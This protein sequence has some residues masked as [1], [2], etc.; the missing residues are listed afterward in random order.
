MWFWGGFAW[1]SGEGEVRGGERCLAGPDLRWKG[2]PDLAVE[3]F[4][5]AGEAEGVGEGGI[6]ERF[7]EGLAEMGEAGEV[8]GESG[9]ELNVLVGGMGDEISE[10]ESREDRDAAAA[11]GGLAG[12]GDDRDA[13]EE[14]VE[15]GGA[16]GIGEGVE[17]DI[18]VVVLLKV[19]GEWGVVGEMDAGGID[20][21]LGEGLA[22]LGS[23]FARLGVEEKAESGTLCRIRAQ[24]WMAGWEIWAKLLSEPKVMWPDWAAGRGLTGGGSPIGW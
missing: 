1:V 17:G 6:Q 12:K 9:G 21:L 7:A 14:G 19:L 20:V 16:A 13:H 10:M 11:G 4:E 8:V 22:E 15:G 3:G 18:H 24:V 5:V 23:V 2:V